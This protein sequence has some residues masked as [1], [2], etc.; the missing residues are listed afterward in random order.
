[1]LVIAL[2][3]KPAR[4]AAFAEDTPAAYWTAR[5]VPAA[6]EF[7]VRYTCHASPAEIDTIV[8]PALSFTVKADAPTLKIREVSPTL[9]SFAGGMV[10]DRPAPEG[11][12][13]MICATILVFVASSVGHASVT[14]ADSVKAR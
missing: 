10:I 11:V 14:F 5:H 8:L 1:M 6:L 13:S 2:R 7:P 9:T 3:P 12:T 4:E